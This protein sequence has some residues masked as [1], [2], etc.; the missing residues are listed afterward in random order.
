MENPQQCCVPDA[1]ILVKI[2]QVDYGHMGGGTPLHATRGQSAR[3]QEPTPWGK[4][5]QERLVFI[6]QT[7]HL[8]RVGLDCIRVAK[9][10]EILPASS[11]VSRSPGLAIYNARRSLLRNHETFDLGGF[12][13][14]SNHFSST[15]LVTDYLRS[16]PSIRIVPI[17]FVDVGESEAT[18]LFGACCSLSLRQ[19]IGYRPKRRIPR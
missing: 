3:V 5:L 4:D 19:C 16:P 12:L 10:Q 11:M 6:P 14:T 9:T 15:S 17:I 7:L 2:P 13:D 1:C 8:Q 18:G